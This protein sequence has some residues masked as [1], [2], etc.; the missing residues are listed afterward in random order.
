MKNKEKNFISAVIYVHNAENRV[1]RF[2]NMIIRVLENNFEH[3]E[4]ICVND[5][6]Q[7]NSSFNF[8][9]I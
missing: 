6:S 1:K 9:T 4:V 8:F 5:C 2:L 3:S 7:D